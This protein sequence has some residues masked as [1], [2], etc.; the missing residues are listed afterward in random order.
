MVPL[1]KGNYTRVLD[2]ICKFAN[3]W[4][5]YWLA[6]TIQHLLAYCLPLSTQTI[7]AAYCDQN[8]PPFPVSCYPSHLS[9][10]CHCHAWELFSLF[11]YSLL[12]PI[13]LA[14]LLQCYWPTWVTHYEFFHLWCP[15]FAWAHW[16][17]AL[18]SLLPS[19]GCVWSSM[20]DSEPQG[21]WQVVFSRSLIILSLLVTLSQVMN[22]I[23][24]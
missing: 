5:V 1:R 20:H 4:H 24:Y 2:C 7:L 16:T 23:W 15:T 17:A 13:S 11:L 6:N 12:W 10:P 18:Y 3:L 21:N 19:W 9:T 22:S 14:P 8:W